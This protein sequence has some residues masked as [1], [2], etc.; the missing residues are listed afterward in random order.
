M[1]RAEVQKALTASTSNVKVSEIMGLIA[2]E[3][4]KSNYFLP[5]PGRAGF[6]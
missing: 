2:K 6:L 1:E 3:E 4:I 5:E